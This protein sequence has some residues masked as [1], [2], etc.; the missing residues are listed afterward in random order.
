VAHDF[1][2]LLGIILSYATFV[3]DRLDAT[4]GS[5]GDESWDEARADMAQIRQAVG[6]AGTLTRQLLSFA[7]REAIR[8]R[9][10]DLN[11]VIGSVEELLRRA[12]GEHIVLTT[13]LAEGLQPVLADAGKI[14]QVLVNLAVNA[15]DAMPCS[16]CPATLGPFLPPRA[17]SP[18]TQSSWTSHS[19]PQTCSTK[20]GRHSGGFAAARCAS[21]CPSAPRGNARVGVRPSRRV[22]R[23]V[24]EFGAA[25]P[26]AGNSSCANACI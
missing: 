15:R 22:N 1:N 21:Q 9:A 19:L 12:I 4:A 7:S 20:P 2:N 3:S 8:P 10:L 25:H 17:G 11:E 6:R 14:E 24:V 5:G 18:L 26:S 16:T 23:D 13:S